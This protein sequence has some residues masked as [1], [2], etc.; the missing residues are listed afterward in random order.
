MDKTRKASDWLKKKQRLPISD[1]AEPSVSV[2]DIKH[3]IYCPRLIYFDKVLHATPIFG[4]QQ[5]DSKELHEDY[6]KK[7][8]RR[9]DAIYYSSELV[10]A[11]KL[12]F[13]PLG[14]GVLGL[15]G[16]VDCIIKTAKEEY[17]PVEYKNMNSDKGKVCMDHKYQLV[18][19][20]LLVEENYKTI[21]KRGFVN[22][23]P[24]TLILQV[25]ITP[26]MKS[27]VKRVLGH[28]KRIIKDEELPPIRVAKQKCT[29]GCGHKQTCQQ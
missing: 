4:S 2:T 10:G 8:L 20:A 16:N 9:K 19:Y 24:E 11:E 14:S 13:T 12:L 1:I 18:G 6:V 26:T 15:Q 3:Y 23:I 7:E 5:E 22:Y 28:I 27:Y 21:V 17:I 29:G 25:E